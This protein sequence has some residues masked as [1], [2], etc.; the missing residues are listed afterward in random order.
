MITK[1]QMLKSVAAAALSTMAMGAALAADITGAGAT[2]PYPVYAKWAEA[3]KAETGT[4]L[5]YQ[6]IGSSG[7]IKQIKAKTV[8]FG[9][10]DAPLG[11]KELDEIGLAQF[12]AIIG[13][14]VPVFNLEGF[15][16]GELRIDGVTLADMFL[17]K[18]TMWNDPK[19]AA[20]NPGKKLPAT[21][22]T[23]VHRAD[24]SGTTYNFTDYLSSV[25][26]EWADSVG[27]NKSVKWPADSS[28]G[29]KGNEGVSANVSRLKGALG[30]VEYAYAKKNN[31][32]YLMLKNADGNFV[33]PD[34]KTF[35]AA[36]AGVDWNSAPGMGASMVNAKGAQSWPITTA[37]FILM[38]KKPESKAQSDEVLKFFDWAFKS[39][40]QLATDLDYVPLPDSLVGEIRTKV[41]STIG[42]SN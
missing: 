39:G 1:R 14:T 37:S 17:G 12:P 42:A 13:G 26:K 9:A 36:A 35:A 22:V 10:S 27:T 2:F 7:G 3:Y 11:G 41:W 30:Y 20:L 21:A 4:G 15:K 32:P 8:T 16:P 31:I 5:N 19:L 40:K 34:D 28:M 6:S 23:I 29:G 38:Y 25:S 33:S 18:I 24:G